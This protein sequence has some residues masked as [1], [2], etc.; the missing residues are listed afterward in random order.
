MKQSPQLQNAQDSMQP[1]VITLH[2]FLG[3]DQ[4]N[5]IDILTEDD[6]TVKR[7]GFSHVLIGKRMEELKEKGK[8][9][10]GEYISVAPH[11]Q[12]RVESV[13]GK[14][15]SPFSGPGL[16][17]KTN[18]TVHN[19]LLDQSVTYTDLHIH[20]IRDHGFYQGKGSRFRLYPV[21]L[22]AILEIEPEDE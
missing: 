4:R 7:L 12:V 10:L 15:P 13:R 19:E 21:E 14:L 6:G 16:Y 17:A 22:S 1:G 3:P 20:L 11:Y 2:G 18:I 8:A 9:G 5:L